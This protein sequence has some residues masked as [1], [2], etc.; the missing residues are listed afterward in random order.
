[1]AWLYLIVAGLFEIGWAIALKYTRD[2]RLWTTVFF[3][4]SMLLS[5]WLLALALRMIPVG[6]GYAVWTGVGA[7]GTAVLGMFL[8][9][10]ARDVLRILG[11][12]LIVVVIVSLK[13]T[14]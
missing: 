10:E 3:G 1:M 7:A 13:L 14:S 5:V 8:F 6:T 11:S 12:T 2:P 9:G 4:V